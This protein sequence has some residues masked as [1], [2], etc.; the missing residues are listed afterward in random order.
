MTQQQVGKKKSLIVR[1][2][3]CMKN[4]KV[5]EEGTLAKLEIEVLVGVTRLRE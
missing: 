1:N 5:A 4:K 3:K 2:S